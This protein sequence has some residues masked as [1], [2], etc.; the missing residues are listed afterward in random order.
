MRTVRIRGGNRPL[1]CC[2]R[3]ATL[4]DLHSG[5]FWDV[6]RRPIR[7]PQAIASLERNGPYR[8]VDAGPSGT[9]AT[10]LKYVLSP[11]SRS[12]VHPVLTPY[13]GDLQN[14][15]LLTGRAP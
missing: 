6:T 15:A 9:L 8:Y 2:D 1:V 3:A 5:H 12:M 13:G 4:A 10:I 14:W 7:F 11:A